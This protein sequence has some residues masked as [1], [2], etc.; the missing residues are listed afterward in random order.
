[1]SIQPI[2]NYLKK[3]KEYN[4][5]LEQ[6]KKT[7]SNLIY[8]VT[9][10]QK[11]IMAT[12]FADKQEQVLLYVVETQV[13]SKEV[14]DDLCNLIS[15]SRVYFFPALDSIPFEVIAQS[16]ET[17]R[18]RLEVMEA[19]ISK[20]AK[21]VVTTFEALSK[22]LISPDIFQKAVVPLKIGQS[23]NIEKLLTHL[24]DV[25]YQRVE[26]IEDKGQFSMRGGILDIFSTSQANPFRLEFF[27]NEIDSIRVFSTESQRSIR[28]IE[29]IKIFPSTELFFSGAE[30][31][32][33]LERI[34]KEGKEY[35]SRL[36][37]REN[38]DGYN[39][40]SEKLKRIQE[41]IL[42]DQF[43]RGYEQLLPYFTE[44]KHTL[45]DYFM[46]RPL[47]IVDEPGRQKESSQIR[48][49]E[50]QET[51]IALLEKGKVLPGQVDNYLNWEEIWEEILEMQTL[52][53]SLLPKKPTGVNAINLLGV[54]GKT[55]SLFMGKTRLLADELKEL[56]RLKYSVVILVNSRERGERLEQGLRDLGVKAALVEK[57]FDILEGQIYITTGYLT[58]GFEL[59]AWRL[60]V[61]TE[62]E[63]YHQPKKRMPRRMFQEG[64]KVT[65][66]ED[67]KLGNLV[68]HINHGIGRYMGIEK[69]IVG[70]SEKDYLV[71]N[72]HGED[73]LYVPTEQVNL[74]QKYSY[75]EGQK[76]RL[77][78]L[79]G[80]EW[81]K[82][83]NKAKSS[84][85]D[86]AEELL[87][88]H[89]TRQSMPG[90]AFSP[91]T[92]WQM[93]FEDAFPY[94][95]TD[96]QLKCIR[97]VKCDME[98][99]RPMDR[100]LC[101][102]VGY[103]KTEVAIRAA[104]KAAIEGKQTAVLV[105][106]TV[107]AQQHYNTFRER[108]EGFPVNVDTLS[109]FRSAKEQKEVIKGLE[110]GQIDV[111]IGTHRL[112]SKDIKFKDLGILIVD[113]EQ[114]F[115][116]IHK[117]KLKKIKKTVDI[118][119]LTATP[120]PRTLHMSLVG[121]RDMSVIE[122]P[123][124][125]RYPVQT[126]VVEFSP[127]LV[128]EAIKREL[129]RG[130]QVYYVHN[131]VEDIEKVATELQ[132]LVPEARIGVAHGKMTELQLE[133]AMLSFMEGELDVLVC[134]TII[135]SGLDISN[136]NTMII[137]AADKLGLSQLYQLR[138]RVGRSNRVAYAYLTYKKDKVLSEIAEKRLNAIRQFT[139]LG[140]GFKI[141]MRDL[142]IRGAGN[143]LGAE[144]SGQIA[145]VGFDLYCR[146]L[147]DAV[148]EA[149]GEELPQEKIVMVDIHVKAFIP[150]EYISDNGMK[151]DFY[152][153]INA[154]KN[155]EELEIIAE[156][157][158]DRFG[159]LP[160]ALTNLLKIA[161]IKFDA[162]LSK[163]VSIIQEKDVIKIKMEN[164]H[165]FT[166]KELMDLARRYRRQVS[167]SASEGLEIIV[168]IRDLTQKQMLTFLK[169][170]LREIYT[171]A[172]KDKVLI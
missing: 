147:E 12:L 25:G 76:P 49:K 123:P 3:G 167:F 13:R 80:S 117:E 87:A 111:V 103:G 85:K 84:V 154:I 171:L 33:A 131:R 163:V 98:K 108:F 17:R 35:L 15:E 2:L 157:L 134:T 9:G 92:P 39:N 125:D 124:E 28:K 94:E 127:Q 5:L 47:V 140:S 51:Y 70:D 10:S 132:G 40:F 69:L 81:T 18:K 137:D 153:R 16:H 105:P 136:V 120:I 106:T 148:T 41:C 74:L 20:K 4:F 118:L 83:K 133:D 150:Q 1:M 21:V 107:L 36:E 165:G 122:T 169:E 115:G 151:I 78:K 14:F 50:I 142:E 88:L 90:F 109:R 55:P 138:G 104:F 19:L 116:V 112:L 11:N 71:I 22:T 58:G 27:D 168:R 162:T 23:C 110:S 57:D 152:Q 155:K 130:G 61:L 8:G 113:E 135:E 114:R 6:V 144:Q 60:V 121:V 44:K 79:G 53:F 43:F 77:S 126:F 156:E 172:I 93:E 31:E 170:I 89:A 75:Q 146:M 129:G 119:T 34:E 46:Q 141:A 32:K 91:D 64:K 161:S 7:K 143:I 65:V 95:E 29:E 139:E 48:E 86:L 159:E 54:T 66:L 63:L 52:F 30:K 38:K 67:L 56:K 97:E 164:D 42:N 62:H 101:G 96:D 72:Y 160:E 59:T 99:A 100:L 45:L 24:V 102:D 82:V 149:K 166:G 26:K 145:A 158:H 73:K 68:V 37:E 128:Q